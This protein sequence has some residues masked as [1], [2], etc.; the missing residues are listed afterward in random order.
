MPEQVAGAFAR[1]KTQQA[2]TATIAAAQFELDFP[3]QTKLQIYC[4]N[5]MYFVTIKLHRDSCPCKL[6][7][8]GHQ[9]TG[10]VQYVMLSRAIAGAP[11]RTLRAI[12]L[13]GRRQLAVSV[14]VL[15]PRPRWPPR[16]CD[17]ANAE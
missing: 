3:Q 17:A 4:F 6:T 16:W 8:F 13:K 10:A 12:F 9:Q 11:G 1:T 2:R 14:L 15:A 5:L 7:K